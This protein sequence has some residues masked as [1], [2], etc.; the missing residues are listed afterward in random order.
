MGFLSAE[1][2]LQTEDLKTEKV[3]VPEW[4]GD[5]LVS[6]MSGEDRDAFERYVSADGRTMKKDINN[7]RAKLASLTLV[8]EHGK[9]LFSELTVAKLGAK[10]GIALSRVCAVATRINCL[11]PESMAELEKNSESPKSGNST[12][13]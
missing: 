3:S 13:G 6:V 9:K 8:D 11:T 1:Q 4:G 7:M 2:I 10:S 5:V 12:F